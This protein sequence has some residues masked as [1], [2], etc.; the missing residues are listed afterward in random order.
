MK[1]ARHLL[2]E[3]RVLSANWTPPVLKG[4]VQEAATSYRAGLVLKSERDVE[5]L[6]GCRPSREWG[7]ICAHSVAVGLRHLKQAQPPAEPAP[8]GAK[9]AERTRPPTSSR[10]S[11]RRLQRAGPGMAGEA[12]DIHVIFPPNLAPAVERNKVMLCFEGNWGGGRT[13]LNALPA[14]KH[15]FFCQQDLALLD[16]IETLAAGETPA[17]LG[18]GLHDLAELLPLLIGHPRLTLGRSTPVAVAKEPWPIGLKA[19]LEANGEIVLARRPGRL[20]PIRIGQDW[21]FHEDKFQPLKLP[22]SCAGVLQ[23]PIRLAR[24]R[25]PQFLSCD[26]PLLR[27]LPDTEANFDLE[28]FLLEPQ[29]PRF[30]LHLGGGL[31]HLEALL[32]CAYGPRVMTLGV[33]AP[34][35]ECWMPDPASP[36]RY[37]TRNLHAE[38][39]AVSRLLRAGF[40][41]PDDQG[42]YR[43]QGQ[44]RVLAFLAREF[45]RMQKEWQVTLEERLERSTRQNVE[46]IEPRF[47]VTA[48]G[49][50]W[51]DLGVSYESSTGERLTPADIQRLLLAGQSH[52]RLRNGRLAVIDTGAVEELQQVLLDCNPQ[53]HE[54]R[55]RLAQSQSGFLAST[56]DQQGWKLQAP[57]AWA[58]RAR[59]QWGEGG[60]ECPPLG[61]LDAVL[62]PYQKVGVS[63]LWFLRRNGFGGIL[64]DEMGLGKTVQ[65]LALLRS[66]ACAPPSTE[67]SGLGEEG[68]AGPTLVVC[69]TSLVFSWVAEAQ[70]VRPRPARAGSAGPGPARLARPHFRV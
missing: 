61:D 19:T 40:R 25:V 6:C 46:R 59:Q 49:I 63:W 65:V 26:W 42:R 66:S 51:F 45:S 48:S 44:D 64:A 3:D 47:E 18:L 70:E 56:L 17:M 24:T 35:E 8:T 4:V 38:R 53:Q 41:G 57:P 11:V 23:G 58:D 16:R 67:S 10:P 21:F 12:A 68:R 15:Y 60:P 32:Q 34:D 31:A 36:V 2:A 30:L 29:P 27:A 50:Q 13:P 55:Y 69:P 52:T 9:G 14:A 43:L 1:Q 7:T 28:D 22:V 37:G 54:G 62:R 33:T 39:E 5:N 20:P